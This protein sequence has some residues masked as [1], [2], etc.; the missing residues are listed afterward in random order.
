MAQTLNFHSGQFLERLKIALIINWLKS[1]QMKKST[2]FM[3]LVFCLS[4]INAQKTLFNIDSLER[5]IK[6]IPRVNFK[7]FKPGEKLEYLVHY[8]F[9]DAGIAT[10]EV[11]DDNIIVG[12]KEVYHVV[13]TGK[14]KGAFDWFFKVRDKYE[15]FIDSE[16]I[17]PY[18]FNRDVSEG[19]YEFQQRYQFFQHRQKVKD[20]RKDK[21]YDA[22]TG[23]QDMISSYYFAR[24]IDLEQYNIGDVIVFQAFVDE[25][26]EPLKIRYLGKEEIEVE[27]GTYNCIKFQPLVQKGR[28]FDDPEDLTVYIT[29]DKNRIPVLAKANVLVGSIKIELISYE[30][31]S[32]PLAK[33]DS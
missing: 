6:A 15:S 18:V 24:T 4:A 14:S 28:I 9:L 20:K 1:E 27:S 30:G 25:E 16:E 23:I 33:G 31:L 5:E 12:G 19:G 7:P 29:D 2:V 22:P 32:H 3:L 17:M 21:E 11:K 26:I 13:G 10:I 8:G